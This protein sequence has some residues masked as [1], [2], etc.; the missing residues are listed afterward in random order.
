MLDFLTGK[1]PFI[2]IKFI[3]QSMGALK[4]KISYVI[5][6]YRGL[7]LEQD[8]ISVSVLPLVYD[9]VTKKCQMSEE[10]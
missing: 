6:W 7:D 5:E 8:N 4:T 9:I 2:E 3:S 1:T 10:L